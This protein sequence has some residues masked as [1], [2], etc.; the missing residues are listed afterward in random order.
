MD[1]LNRLIDNLIQEKGGSRHDYLNLL[2]RIAYHESAG[3]MDPKLKQW[4]GGP[5]RGKYQFEEG[6]N[7]GAITA[8]KRTA[9]YLKSKGE[10]IPSWLSGSLKSKSLDAT[11]LHP[12]QQDMLFLGNMRMHPRADF[13]KIWNGEED[14]RDFWANYHWAGSDSDRP[15]RLKSF[16]TSDSKFSEQFPMLMEDP[17]AMLKFANGG[18]SKPNTNGGMVDRELNS[19][20]VGG[21]HETNPHG[22]VPIGKG[23]NGKVN[24]VEQGE[25]SYPVGDGKYVFSD[26][27]RVLANGGMSKKK[28]DPNKFETGGE[29][30]P[31]DPPQKKVTLQDLAKS[32]M[33]YGER[34]AEDDREFLTNWFLSDR[35]NNKLSEHLKE[36]DSR[37][38]D[39][40]YKGFI[41]KTFN[42]SLAEDAAM[43]RNKALERVKDTPVF[44]N[45]PKDVYFA[46][47]YPELG[48]RLTDQYSKLINESEL[49]FFE[50][51]N[52]AY[53]GVQGEYNTLHNSIWINKDNDGTTTH[54]LTHSTPLDKFMR[55]VIP[56]SN[57]RQK[58]DK[59]VQGLLGNEKSGVYVPWLSDDK[60][61]VIS[62]E[63]VFGI[64]PHRQ[65]YTRTGAKDLYKK[66]DSAANALNYSA[67][68]SQYIEGGSEVYPRIMSI[69][70]QAG[71]K[72]EDEITDELM[73][74]IYQKTKED[75]LY[76][77]YDKEEVKDLLNKLASNDTAQNLNVAA[78]GG[79]NGPDDPPKKKPSNAESQYLSEK[80]Y[81]KNWLNDPITA[82]KFAEKLISQREYNHY[83]KEKID[84]LRK[85]AYWTPM[86]MSENLDNVNFNIELSDDNTVLGAYNPARHSVNV[87]QQNPSS[88]RKGTGAHEFSHASRL[89]DLL[90]RWAQR[91]VGYLSYDE[92]DLPGDRDYKSYLNSLE[93]FPRL[94]KMRYLMNAKPGQKIKVEDLDQFKKEDFPILKYYSREQVKDLLNKSVDASN[95]SD[96]IKRL[97]NYT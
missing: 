10:E 38:T 39:S 70:R 87:Y 45:P 69:R 75:Y 14:V 60:F 50:R 71:L 27:L 41:D 62:E 2:D 36:V 82:N 26:R 18:Y 9:Q 89:D 24:T 94:M 49:D 5:G 12:W 1:E 37:K 15:Q 48:K 61:K 83:P 51:N 65:Y 81:V 55:Q 44:S 66:V 80:D 3:T 56:F 42:P 47:P 57:K 13:S 21:R 54:E 58:L 34:F 20:G 90:S 33:N 64:V 40:R 32:P 25:T 78:Y 63:K 74:K 16:D 59:Y 7:A 95:I 52:P 22:G 79:Y 67:K 92:K 30:G 84:E 28:V 88:I 11:K 43:L 93:I 91:D 6:S 53:S 4:G 35:F 17:E 46:N 73:E 23:G 76:E 85:N 86:R 31:D 97:K 19:F 72:P 8:A 29:A 96:I 68:D 77:V